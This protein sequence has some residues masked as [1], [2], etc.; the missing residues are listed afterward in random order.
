MAASRLPENRKSAA[1]CRKTLEKAGLE[2]V[3]LPCPPRIRPPAGWRE[4]FLPATYANFLITNKMVLVP[5]YGFPDE[6]AEA[7]EIVG[8]C[9]PDRKIKGI[10]CRNI[11]LEGGALHC[12]SQQMPE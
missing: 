8:K 6:D 10:N 7:L 1:S 5:V 12:L 11:I 2:I 4:E 9:F 3:E